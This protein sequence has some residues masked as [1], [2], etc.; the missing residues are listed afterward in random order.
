MGDRI[1]K[2]FN[3]EVEL[4]KYL[5]AFKMRFGVI[6]DDSNY[7]VTFYDNKTGALIYQG[8]YQNP[9]GAIR[10][11]N[12]IIPERKIPAQDLDIC[13]DVA[14]KNNSN[15]SIRFGFDEST[16]I[17]RLAYTLYF[18]K[19]EEAPEAAQREITN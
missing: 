12:T 17:P 16:P 13:I 7:V 1:Y 9:I 5:D 11:L 6:G 14:F 10:D 19:K 15:L 4:K 2:D 8:I 3:D 18:K